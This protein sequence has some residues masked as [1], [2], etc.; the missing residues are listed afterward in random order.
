MVCLR[1]NIGLINDFNEIESLANQ[2]EDSGGV[3]FV[4][5]FQGLF[6]PYWDLNASGLFIGLSQFTQKS[7]LV[8]AMLESVAFQTTD[9]LALMKPSRSGLK[10]DGGM[11]AND[12]LCQIISDL[13]NV[14][15]VRP[16]KIEA[17]ALGCAMI[18]GQTLSLFHVFD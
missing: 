15:V 13:N 3:Y 4:P 7:H 17:T 6:A 12:T 11:A 8:R 1:D 18:S 5:A 10:V 2:V 16:A 9:I 14:K